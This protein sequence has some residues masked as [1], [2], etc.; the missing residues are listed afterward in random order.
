MRYVGVLGRLARNP[1]LRRVLIAFVGFNMAEWG[2][3]VA[4]LVYA[5]GHGGATTAAVVAVVQLVP[6]A[7]FAPIAGTLGDRHRPTR[8]LAAGYAAQGAAMGATAAV[9][10]LHGAPDAAYALAAVA[11]SAVTI[12]RPAQAGLLPALARTPEELTAANV[13]AGW[14]ESLSVLAGPALA[15]LLLGAGGAGAVFAV[16]AGAALAAS[17]LVAPLAGPAA[18]APADAATG[19]R[20]AAAEPGPR[21]LVWLLGVEAFA[22][23]AL[24]VLYVVLAVGVLKQGG[25]S[26]GY[27]NAAFGAGGVVGIGATVA[28]VGRRRLAPALLGGLVVWSAAL[29]AV[30]LVGSIA[31]A[32]A[33][34]VAAGVG[35]TVV[36][37][38]GR[39]L[40]Q[41]IARP[42]A[43]ARVFGLLEGVS[44]VG[45]A[46]GSLAAAGFVAVAG[47][48]GAFVCL[49]AAL[50]VAALLVLRRVLAA[51]SAVL[52]VVE[53][54]RLRA[55][56]LF[57]PLGA[58]ALEGLARSLEPV[59][60]PPGRV[61]VRE[62]EPGECFYVVAEGELG[63]SVGGASVATLARGECFGEIALLRDVPRT[64][65]VTAET[66]V[67]L[68]VLDKDVFLAAVC[69][70][71]PSERAADELVQARLERATIAP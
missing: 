41:R 67:R 59:E 33:L 24:D 9:L 51:D 4:M 39:T 57:A 6:A 11:A 10:L 26:A 69:G 13:A 37:V 52:P 14:I 1:E 15:G 70:F 38:A 17:V 25:G 68:D 60:V 71:A 8:V 58:P 12:T 29:A 21:A 32:F 45:L 22:I 30:G 50:P 20:A 5:Y 7:L 62:G 55:L 18:G 56:P 63:V 34:F 40:L 28:L 49:A 44:M 3:W 66:S 36:D 42:D 35:R 53:I 64:A 65:T 31:A 27:V 16:F 2:V 43:L 48:R 19:V 47:G 61:I 54:A 23:G 46:A